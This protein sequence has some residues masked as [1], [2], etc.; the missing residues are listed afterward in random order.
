M[1]LFTMKAGG[2]ATHLFPLRCA[3][4]A[5]QLR[6]ITSSAQDAAESMLEKYR[7]ATMV[8][9]QRLDP[10]QSQKLSLML[11]RQD[12]QPGVNIVLEPPKTGTH[13]PPGYHLVYMTP[14]SI[15]GDLGADGSD[16]TYNPPGCFTRRMWAGGSMVWNKRNNLCVGDDV[17]ERT[18]LLSAVPKMSRSGHE[19]VLVELE[20]EFANSRGVALI[21]RRYA[22]S[23]PRRYCHDHYLN[24]PRSI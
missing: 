22:H 19:M 16:K 20:K 7:G 13:L 24:K 10:Q 8:Q 18:R 17:E 11:T 3:S 4:K 15:E 14:A 5:L 21:D 9:K 23:C 12:L 1:S 2:G 6:T